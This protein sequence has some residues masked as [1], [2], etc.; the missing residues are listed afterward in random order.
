MPP[1]TCPATVSTWDRGPSHSFH[2][3]YSR[4]TS[5]E[6]SDHSVSFSFQMQQ[7]LPQKHEVSGV[8]PSHQHWALSSSLSTL[9]HNHHMWFSGVHMT[10]YFRPQ[11]QL[12]AVPLST[13]WS[14][15]PSSSVSPDLGSDQTFFVDTSDGDKW[16]CLTF[17][18][19]WLKS[20]VDEGTG[21]SRNAFL[22][23]MPQCKRL[24]ALPKRN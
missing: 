3:R 19:Y 14:F 2:H 4:I 5:G 24:N 10:C 15:W 17:C 11:K 21:I 9:L 8:P 16:C 12:S 18:S 1:S 22:L 6:R 7:K 13:Y 23:K 20:E